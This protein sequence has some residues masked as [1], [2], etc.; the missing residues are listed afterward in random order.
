[1]ASEQDKMS[2]LKNLIRMMCVDGAVS[3]REKRFLAQAAGQ[4]G[5]EIEDWNGLLK[6]VL[7]KK[8]RLDEFEDRAAGIAALKAMVVMAKA[9]KRVEPEEKDLLESFAKSLGVSTGEWATIIRDID[10]D[11]IFDVFRDA[12]ERLAGR[13]IVVVKEDF[14]KVDVLLETLENND[15]SGR[16]VGF[17]EFLHG[18]GAGDTPV[19]IHA[20][21]SREVSLE[22]YR[23]AAEKAAKVVPI[24]TRYQGAQVKYLLEAGAKTCII[25]PVY[26]RDLE[27]VFEN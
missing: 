11:D 7:A 2:C 16:V 17:D 15:I 3:G 12:K 24:L 19:F 26:P 21:H 14:D 9:D 5:L 13:T 4:L 6:E 18:Q 1:M 23:K 20:G 25:E 10:V 27:E 8:D 22:R